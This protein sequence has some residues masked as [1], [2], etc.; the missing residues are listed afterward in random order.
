MA[1][2][3]SLSASRNR[4]GQPKGPDWHDNSHAS[5][6]RAQRTVMPSMEEGSGLRGPELYRAGVR[7]AADAPNRP[8]QSI[9]EASAKASQHVSCDKTGTARRS[10]WWSG[11]TPAEV[12]IKLYLLGFSIFYTGK[13]TYLAKRRVKWLSISSVMRNGVAGDA[14]GAADAHDDGTNSRPGSER[15]RRRPTSVLRSGA[16]G[17]GCEA[18][19]SADV[20]T[21][22]G[23]G[24]RRFSRRDRRGRSWRRR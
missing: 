21:I 14:S 20:R 24:A 1:A 7:R 10:T 6:A 15:R 23:R 5:A 8:R 11:Y 17:T 19:Y 4:R 22:T 9:G 3:E 2:R 13:N 12:T 18:A 16:A